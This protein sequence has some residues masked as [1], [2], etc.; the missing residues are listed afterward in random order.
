MVAM[1]IIVIS[2]H[3]TALDEVMADIITSFL[4][5][6]GKHSKLAVVL[7]KICDKQI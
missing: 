6:G 7:I 1:V 3:S 5:I 2:D 4:H